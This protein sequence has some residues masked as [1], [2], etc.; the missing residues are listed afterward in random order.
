MT[1]KEAKEIVATSELSDKSLDLALAIFEGLADADELPE[2]KMNQI[3]AIM[4]ADANVEE[5]INQPVDEDI[6]IDK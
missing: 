5:L 3:I 4:D 6:P 2:E 1:V